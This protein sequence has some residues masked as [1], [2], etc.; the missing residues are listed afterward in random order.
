MF[1]CHLT[2]GVQDDVSIATSKGTNTIMS[3]E[4]RMRFIEGLGVV[5][6]VISYSN[7]DQSEV[8]GKLR[9]TVLIIGPE[10]GN[11]EE[12]KRTLRYCEENGTRV[13]L[14]E[15]TRGISTTCIKTR[16]LSC[17]RR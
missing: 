13:E 10:F 9:A 6:E 11:C 4:E 8:L 16:L 1:D 7:R 17:T 12:H 14:I 15:R 5:D 2:V 3:L